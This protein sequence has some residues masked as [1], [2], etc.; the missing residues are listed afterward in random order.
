MYYNQEDK[1]ITA[2]FIGST[3]GYKDR[4][5]YLDYAL[6]KQIDLLILGGQREGRLTPFEYAEHIRDSKIGI[7][8][9]ESPSGIDQCKGR[10]IEI[11]SCGSMLLER[12]NEATRK[13]LTPGED[14]VEFEGL[15]DF[16]EKINFYTKN[17]KERERIAKNGYQKYCNNFSSSKFWT[18]VLTRCGYEL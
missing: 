6:E 3:R 9:P 17:H 15:D 2:S 18:K 10:V 7:N 1:K 11:I 5:M 4:R 12:K 16:V 8:F 13:N 14:Y